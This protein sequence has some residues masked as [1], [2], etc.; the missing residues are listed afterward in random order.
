MHRS[1]RWHPGRLLVGWALGVL[2]TI[3]LVTLMGGWYEYRQLSTA[4]GSGSP[5]RRVASTD[6]ACQVDRDGAINVDGF[7]VVPAQDDP[8]YLRR[9]RIRPWQWADGIREQLGLL[10]GAVSASPAGPITSAGTVLAAGLGHASSRASA[11]QPW[12]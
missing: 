2:T 1:S 7:E 5:G 3:G 11:P 4:P 6:S 8:C 10:S 9:P 12:F